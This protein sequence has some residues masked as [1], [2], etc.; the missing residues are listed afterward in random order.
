[1]TFSKK[2]L[3]FALMTLVL[4]GFAVAQ[5]TEISYMCWYNTTESEAQGVQANIDKFNASQDKIHVTMIAIP[6]DGYETKVNTMAA[7]GQ[8]PTAPSSRKPWRSSS[9]PPTSSPT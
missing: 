4:A 2:F 1:M 3:V 9:P 6:R 8:L 7:A 5:K